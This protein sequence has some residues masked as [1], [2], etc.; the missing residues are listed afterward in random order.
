[1][2]SQRRSVRHMLMGV[3]FAVVL[4]ACGGD[5]AAPSSEQ[6]APATDGSVDGPADAP[7]GAPVDTR[8]RSPFTGLP[9]DPEVLERALLVVKIENSEN[10]RPQTGMDAADIVIE[11]LVEGGITRFMVLFHSDLPAVAGPIRSA[12][13]VDVD[14]LSGLGA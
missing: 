11:E 10:A 1:M 9:V 6:P 7:D 5:G 8:P 14:L 4:A 12:R 13:P 2:R 3:A